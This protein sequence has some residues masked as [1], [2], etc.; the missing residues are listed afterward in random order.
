MN[1]E[2]DYMLKHRIIEWSESAWASL[3]VLVEK[4]DRTMRFC[5]DYRKINAVTKADCYPIPRIEDCIDRIGRARFIT[6]CDLLKG[7]WVIPLTEKAKEI[8]AFVVPDGPFQYKVMPF[9]MRNLQVTFT[10]M[11]N[12][13]LEGLTGVDAYVDDIVVYSKT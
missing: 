3:C 11:V 4:E 13:C 5:T 6:K 10:R 2:L 8:S 7:Y 1:T 9:G 12:K